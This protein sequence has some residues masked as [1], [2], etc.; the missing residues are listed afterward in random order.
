MSMLTLKNRGI[1]DVSMKVVNG[2]LVYVKFEDRARRGI[3]LVISH[4]M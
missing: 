3:C 1:W 4:V 2:K